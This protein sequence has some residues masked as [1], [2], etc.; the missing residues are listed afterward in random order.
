M[1]TPKD[2]TNI[3][4]GNLIS[5]EFLLALIGFVASAALVWGS[6]NAQVQA[7]AVNDT[8]I[9]ATQTSFAESL[10]QIKVSQEVSR[11]E[12]EHIKEQLRDQAAN[13]HY[14]ATQVDDIKNILIE[15]RAD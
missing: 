9:M 6:L 4:L 13:S 2:I 14:I 15:L 8:V 11:V 1:A 7:N 3:K 10:D 12:I 5:F